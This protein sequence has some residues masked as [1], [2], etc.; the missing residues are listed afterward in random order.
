[1]RIGPFQGK[2]VRLKLGNVSHV[3]TLLVVPNGTTRVHQIILFFVKG[4]AERYKTARLKMR[5][6]LWL[7]RHR[8]V[9]K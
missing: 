4:A 3:D 5:L 7:L 1:M 9:G 2:T 8:T 6:I